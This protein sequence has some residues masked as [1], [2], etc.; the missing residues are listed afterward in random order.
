MAALSAMQ[1]VWFWSFWHWSKESFQAGRLLRPPLEGI[2]SHW[3]EWFCHEA[4]ERDLESIEETG[5][6]EVS[7]RQF[8]RW[9]ARRWAREAHPGENRMIPRFVA[10]PTRAAAAV[11]AVAGAGEVPKAV[12]DGGRFRHCLG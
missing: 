3:D 7:Q 9:L 2:G 5:R 10:R 1:F 11:Q 4:S 6:S 8:I 12:R